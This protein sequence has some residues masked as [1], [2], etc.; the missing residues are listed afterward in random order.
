MN[1][2][3]ILLTIGNI[4]VMTSIFHQMYKNYKGKNTRTQSIYWQIQTLMGYVMFLWGYWYLDMMIPFIGVLFNA[5]LKLVLLLQVL[6]YNRKSNLLEN[7][8]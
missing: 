6:Y 3:D 4:I 5:M 2:S 7:W 1:V 8:V